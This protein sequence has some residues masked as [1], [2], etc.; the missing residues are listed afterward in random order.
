[1][2][3]VI[4]PAAA[5]YLLNYLIASNE[6]FIVGFAGSWGPLHRGIRGGRTPADRKFQG[7]KTQEQD[8][9][10]VDLSKKRPMSSS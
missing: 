5:A 6:A 10:K 7:L 3:N 8:G 4:P 2:L 9:R 1:M